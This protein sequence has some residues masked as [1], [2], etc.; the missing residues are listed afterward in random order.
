MSVEALSVADI[1]GGDPLGRLAERAQLRPIRLAQ[2]FFLAGAAYLGGLAAAFGYLLPRSGLVA[3]QADVFNQ[4][5]FFIIF[6]A[7][8]FYYLWQPAALTRVYA[9]IRYLTPDEVEAA[10]WQGIRR[11]NA[12][13]GWWLAGGAFA[14]LGMAAGALDNAA[15]LGVWWYAANWLMIAIL[16]IFRG[17]VFYMLASIVGRHFAATVGLNRCYRQFEIP[18]MVLPA[19]RGGIRA[20]GR[21]AF[22]FTVLLAV[23]G[24]NLGTAPILSLRMGADYPY[25][26][27]AYFLVAPLGFILPLWQAHQHMVQNRD[28]RLNDLAGQFQAEYTRL[29][30]R[31]GRSQE[32]AG[33]ER[34]K[35][36]EEAYDWTRKALTWPF[37]PELIYQLAATIVA[38][39]AFTL[40]QVLLDRLLK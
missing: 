4:L 24:L 28:R 25:Q 34:L 37:N 10:L 18:L 33:T 9:D 35:S 32:A 17:L 7:V 11:I 20:V 21:Y 26:V 6:P 5:N 2:I 12:H 8:A 29:L 15:R 13:P 31:L 30:E 38:P 39:F 40:L 16:Q 1:I 14:A 22:S 36:I 19:R 23:V 3:S 27:A